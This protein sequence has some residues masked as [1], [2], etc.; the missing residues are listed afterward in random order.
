MAGG[1]ARHGEGGEGAPGRGDGLGRGHQAEVDLDLAAAVWSVV[2]VLIVTGSMQLC[3]LPALVH[4]GGAAVAARG[5][6]AVGDP[7]QV[8]A[9]Q[10]ALI[11]KLY[12]NS[13]WRVR[14]AN[15]DRIGKTSKDSSSNGASAD[16][17][18]PL[19]NVPSIRGWRPEGGEWGWRQGGDQH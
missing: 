18:Y 19:I 12:A 2:M 1:G 10:G 4:L 11:Q 13:G 6:A 17:K 14:H 16:V 8:G 9:G 15:M 7:D 3:H 5:P